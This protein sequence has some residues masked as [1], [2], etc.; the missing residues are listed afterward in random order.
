MHAVEI[1][2]RLDKSQESIYGQSTQKRS[3]QQTAI[4]CVVSA[5]LVILALELIFTLAGVG[6]EEF[7]RVDPVLG[8]SP[9][10][11]K[12]LTFRSEGYSQS[13]FNSFGMRDR[14]ISK[15]KEPGIIRI[16]V[17]G[18]SMTE[19]LQVNREQSFPSFFEE[20]L[21]DGAQKKK[22][23]VLNF[24]VSSYYFPQ[25]YLRL[26]HLAL[27]F[28][29]NLAIIEMRTGETLELLPKPL[30]NLI[31]AR[32]FFLVDGSDKLIESHVFQNQWNKGREA[33][34]VR[35]TSW[36]REHSSLWGVAGI[37]MQ[38]L[39]KK[40]TVFAEV[41]KDANAQLKEPI[42]FKFVPIDPYLKR[43]TRSLILQAKKDCAAHNCE[44]ALIYITS[45]RGVRNLEE[46][47]FL[48]QAAKELG[49]PF[50]NL[51][52]PIERN[53]SSAKEPLYLSHLAPRGHKLVAD[54]L[55]PFVT[56]N[57]PEMFADTERV[58][59]AKERSNAL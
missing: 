58:R 26:K 36:L 4:D 55:V 23:E 38:R 19:A 15:I 24:G 22:Y 13:S 6:Q 16:A 57:Y 34:R 51:R 28:K 30:S 25:K 53:V 49:V 3:L 40:P 8:C 48:K 59:K 35:S 50:L 45:L 27:D 43:L 46:E 7:L 5:V 20:N 21:N 2:P 37:G 32:P 31:S 56:K 47:V 17:L 11:G 12:K 1:A 42:N 9:M 33:S 52:E 39:M 10:P 29:P 18:D 41:K 14:E 54:E 44:L